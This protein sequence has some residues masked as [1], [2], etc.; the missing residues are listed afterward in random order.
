MINLVAMVLASIA[1]Y[2]VHFLFGDSLSFFADFMIGSV[3]GG[4]VYIF[5]IYRLRKLRGDF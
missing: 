3:V 4:V 5:T 1:A 2:G